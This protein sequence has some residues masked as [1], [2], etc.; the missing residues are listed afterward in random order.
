M[1]QEYLITFDEN[2]VEKNKELKKNGEP[3]EYRQDHLIKVQHTEMEYMAR[4]G[5]SG[6]Y[7]QKGYDYDYECL[8]KKRQIQPCTTPW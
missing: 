2:L 1:R 3:I 8:Y 4:Q 7:C 5:D 6:R